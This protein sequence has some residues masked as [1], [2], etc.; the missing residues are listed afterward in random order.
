MGE[1]YYEYTHR[2]R[3]LH[4]EPKSTAPPELLG[5]WKKI[6]DKVAKATRHLKKNKDRITYY[7]WSEFHSGGWH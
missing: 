1:L 3:L 7:E 2:L 5:K 4:Q 6:E